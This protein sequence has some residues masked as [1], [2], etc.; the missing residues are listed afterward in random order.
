MNIYF[1]GT[2]GYIK[3]S[4][5]NH[6]YHTSLYI[7]YKKTKILIDCG[8]GWEKRKFKLNPVDAILL[9][10]WHPDHTYGLKK[11]ELQYKPPVYATTDTWKYINKFPISN[12]KVIRYNKKFKIGEITFEPFEVLHTLK[13]DAVG[14]KITIG[15]KSFFYV[16]DMISIIKKQKALK[17][18]LFYV[19]DGSVV[20]ESLIRRDKKIGKIYGHS[21]IKA[22]ASM[23][24]KQGVNKMYITHCGTEIVNDWKNTKKEINKIEN[25]YNIIIIIVYD[26]MRL[27]I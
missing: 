17:N 1:L 21:S 25:K 23:C 27:L 16:S 22:Q 6:K 24:S 7:S 14:Y 4:N 15:Y 2:K 11:N 13:Y 3:E 10:H 19:G 5:N 18:I 9:T 26:S 12:R 20:N 8:I